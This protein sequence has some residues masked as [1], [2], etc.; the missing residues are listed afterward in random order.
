MLAIIRT[1]YA[2][3]NAS[4]WLSAKSGVPAV[5]L[6]YTIGGAPG[7]SNLFSL[8]DRSLSLLGELADA[9]R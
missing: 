6:P 8:F 4:E 7:V 2:P 5:V 1:P 3:G 9:K